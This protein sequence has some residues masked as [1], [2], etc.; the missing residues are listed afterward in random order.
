[1]KNQLP[2][3]IKNLNPA[4]KKV[5]AISS[6]VALFCILFLSFFLWSSTY[7]NPKNVKPLSLEQSA[8]LTSFLNR[9]YSEQRGQE[10]KPLPYPTVEAKMNLA[11]G[12]AILIDTSNGCILFE[13][14]ADQ[15]I[16]PASITKLF[17]MYIA[18]KEIEA[19]NLSLDELVEPPEISWAV[20]LPR[21]S[22][23]MF[24]GQ[25][26]KVSVNELLKGLA[27][28]SGND[29]AL[30][31]AYRISGNTKDFIKRMNYEAKALGL[32]K[33]HFEE[34]SGY[35][36]NNLTTA[37]E[38]AEF[39]RIY[40]NRYPQS[41]KDF[42]S[43]N[44][45]SYPLQ[46]NLPSWQ[47]EKGDSLAITQK[48]T[49]PL[50]NRLK[51]CD[52]LKTGFIYESGYNLALTASREGV[53]FLSVT[54]KG[55]GT[56][57]IEGNFYRVQDG[58]KLMEWAFSSFADYF[59]QKNTA[60]IYTVACL[61]SKEKFIN[62]LP[63]WNNSITVPHIKAQTVQED[64]ASIV[65]QVQ[66]PKYIDKGVQVGQVFG[67]ISYKLGDTVLETVPLVADR[68]VTKANALKRL[69]GKLV[70]LRF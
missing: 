9:T 57:S 32:E 54:M 61:G 34:P 11:S 16:P 46:K 70:A 28:A 65:A 15:I 4:Q 51:G 63:A 20:N 53:R 18:F 41:L 33:T 36:E 49:N 68:S 29:A 14:N 59:P 25:G 31:L 60:Q 5:V 2:Q 12:S 13:K 39:C 30:A 58:T 3:K 21:D 17:V 27:V 26:Q 67:Q 8:T 50:L 23:L 40:I 55:P 64:A 38:L 43:L 45:I 35:S 10:L 19:G 56:N 6:V 44:E 66:I 42:H 62:L 52:G 24:L 47:T 48:N 22:S 1:M 69:L 37:R 7:L